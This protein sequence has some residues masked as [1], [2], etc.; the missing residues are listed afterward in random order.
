MTNSAHVVCVGVITLDTIAQVVRY[1]EADERVLASQIVRA[2]GGPAAV[3]AVAIARSGIPVSLIGTIGED[4]DGDEVLRILKS[5]G[6]GTEGISIGRQPTAGSVIIA[7]SSTMSRAIATRQPP[8]QDPV[9]ANAKQL[10]QSADWVHVDHVGINLLSE[11]GVIRGG[12]AKISFDAG[13]EIRD[14]D[15][16][17]VDYFVPSDRAILDRHV[18]LSLEEAMERDAVEGRNTVIVTKGSEGSAGFN[19]ES[20]HFQAAGFSSEIVS[21]LGAGDVF[22]GAL[23]AQILLGFPLPE[24]IRRANATAAMSCRSLDGMSGIPTLSE[25]ENY[26]KGRS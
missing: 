21:T 22:H 12:R 26:L 7:A 3:A 10:A 4:S 2:G 14:T 11:L 6:V 1:P 18:G 19:E 17:L 15:V 5:E 13:Y 24:V 23:V 16:A 25:L 8:K 20:G 9:T